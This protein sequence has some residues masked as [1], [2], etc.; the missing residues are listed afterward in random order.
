MLV[1]IYDDGQSLYN[2]ESSF[3]I[4]R[5]LRVQVLR[6]TL[7]WGGRGGVAVRRPRN[8]ADPADPAYDWTAYDRAVLNAQAIGARVLFSIY[9]TPPWENRAVGL[10]RAPR[11]AR[12]LQ[13]FAY[14]AAMRYSGS[15]ERSDGVRLPPV[16]H[17]LAWNEPN[18]PVF[19]KP[20]FRRAGGRWVYESARSYA[21]ICN[22]VYAGV[23]ATLAR[24]HKVGC[25]VTAPRGNNDPSSVRPSVSPLAFLRALRATGRVRFDAY[26]HHPYYGN[27]FD[28]P[29]TRPRPAPN[30]N[31]VTAVTLGNIQDLVSELTRLYGRKPVWVTEYGYQTNPPDDFFGVSWAAQARYLSQ[32]FAIARRHPRIDMMLWY[33]LQDEPSLGGWQS[34]L[35]TSN[36]ERKPS[37]RAFQRLPR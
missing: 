19:L 2:G 33:L 3:P 36:G 34:G 11:D 8:A 10:N 31:R 14:A 12:N 37:F 29:N 7:L 6:M 30:T 25:G 23:H 26:A 18:N 5:Q 21:R 15:Y 16:R 17:W 22:A 20:Q 1:G 32:A 24:G 13:R 27:A 9:G 35:F 4:Y 28:K